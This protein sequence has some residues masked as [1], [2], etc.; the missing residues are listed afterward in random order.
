MS[1]KSNM[2]DLMILQV[3]SIIKKACNRP[4]KT[5]KMKFIWK[6]N[7]IE[8]SNILTYIVTKH[9]FKITSNLIFQDCTINIEH[10]KLKKSFYL[11]TKQ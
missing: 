3:R 11:M 9:N 8:T 6:I 2:S 7:F 5:H 1:G 10:S 4:S